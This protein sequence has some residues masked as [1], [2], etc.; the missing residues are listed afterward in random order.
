MNSEVQLVLLN[1]GISGC[2]NDLAIDD[3][4]LTPVAPVLTFAAE[5]DGGTTTVTGS[6]GGSF[7]FNPEPGDGAVID[8]DTGTIAGGTP[9]ANYTIEYSALGGCSTTNLNVTLLLGDDSSFTMTPTCDGGTA[10]ITGDSGG[11]FAFNPVPSDGAMID[12]TTGIVSGGTTDTSYTV[13]YTTTAGTC[14]TTTVVTFTTLQV[15]DASFTMTPTCDG[16]TA[17]ITGDSG[18]TFAL[19]PTPS[20]GAVIDATTGTVSGGATGTSYTVE[21]STVGTCPITNSITVTTLPSDDASFTMTPTCDGGTATITGDSGGTF[22]FNPVPSDGAVVDGATGT[23]TGGTFDTSYTVEYTTADLCPATSVITFTVLPA[24]DASFT[25]TATCD[26]ATVTI[27]GDTGGT[28][29]FNPLPTDSAVIDV[30]SG[31]ITSG[32]AGETYTVEYTTAGACPNSSVQ[33]VTLLTNVF[34]FNIVG[35]C[36]GSIFELTITPI[37]NSYN[38]NTATYVLYDDM[39]SVLI[40]NSLGENVFEISPNIFTEP[41]AGSAYNYVVEVTNAEGCVQTSN[42]LVENINCIIPQAISP[43]DDNFNDNFDLSGYDVSRLE[44]YNRHGVKVYSKT[45]YTNEW[46]GQTDDGKE[47]PVG[48][49]F[50]V[51]EYQGNKTK[52]SWVYI[53]K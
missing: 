8:P 37:G 11:T 28:F 47:L 15:D 10:T 24:D 23:V 52:S 25:M 45:N 3:I 18:G 29:A 26:S 21:Y 17:T 41:M 51:M 49:Y 19:N 30:F 44:I 4:S 7:V 48:T 31:T 1:Q 22:A 2:G 33:T 36:N 43:N 53:N 6:T 20:D 40:A 14:P 9:G 16:G 42:A 12:I 5:C 50:Y 39:D 34:E 27:T 32:T 13:E 46:Y 35:D 38:P